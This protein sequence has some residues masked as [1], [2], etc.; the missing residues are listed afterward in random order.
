MSWPNS[1]QSIASPANSNSLAQQE[2]NN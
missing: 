1:F 2:H